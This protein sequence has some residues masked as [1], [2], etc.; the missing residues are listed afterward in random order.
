L[1]EGVE[2]DRVPDNIPPSPLTPQALRLDRAAGLSDNVPDADLKD[3]MPL[4]PSRIEE[5]RFQGMKSRVSKIVSC[6]GRRRMPF[7]LLS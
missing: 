6:F 3:E 2:I 5:G 1:K 7:V 4:E